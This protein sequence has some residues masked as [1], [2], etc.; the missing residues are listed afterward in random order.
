M[1][2]GL[3]TRLESK[4]MTRDQIQWIQDPKTELRKHPQGT[5][6]L[7]QT[8]GKMVFLC[9]LSGNIYRKGDLPGDEA[10][11]FQVWPK[12]NTTTVETMCSRGARFALICQPS[13]G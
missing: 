9:N 7:M 10:W 13:N 1:Q 8:K 4:T 12:G 3:N 11:K 2:D 6:F 5:M